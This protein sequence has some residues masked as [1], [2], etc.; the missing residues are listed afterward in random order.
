MPGES[1]V[2][3]DDS[4]TLSKLVQLVL[5][6]MG[7]QVIVASNDSGARDLFKTEKPRLVLLDDMLEDKPVDD[8]CAHI[9]SLAPHAPG[10]VL[11]RSGHGPKD[12]SKLPG[13]VDSITKPFSPEALK[14]L[15]SHIVGMSLQE[16][17]SLPR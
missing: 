11:L 2:V 12:P 5:G 15:V 14:A 1:I 17:P 8:L 3:I 9:A 10:V 13:V 7:L 6:E 16:G 4:P